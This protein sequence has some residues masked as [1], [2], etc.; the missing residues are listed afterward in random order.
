M[1]TDIQKSCLNCKNNSC[2]PMRDKFCY[3]ID[4]ET[5]IEC[6]L[7]EGFLEETLKECLD[8]TE[9]YKRLQNE[10]IIKKSIKIKDIDIDDTITNFIEKLQDDL[11]QS[12][13]NHLGTIELEQCKMTDND[14]YCSKW[15]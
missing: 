3:D 2:C 6:K 14:F 15:E 13:V 11:W 1:N 10:G 8:L 7:E 9:I 4:I 5:A 12:I